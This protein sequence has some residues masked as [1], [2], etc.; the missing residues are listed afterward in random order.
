MRCVCVCVTVH[1]WVIDWATERVQYTNNFS[2]STH[3][4]TVFLFSH[5]RVHKHTHAMLLLH[6][7]TMTTANAAH[8][9]GPH[10]RRSSMV[11]SCNG[12]PACKLCKFGLTIPNY[13]FICI[14]SRLI[15]NMIFRTS[16]SLILNL[17]D[18]WFK[19][20]HKKTCLIFEAISKLLQQHT[21]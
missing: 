21:I 10:Q 19:W 7:I 3:S 6:C 1:K 5:I 2:L 8:S 15:E 13:D 11:T 9:V 20:K 4:S 18:Y 17:A 16:C 12:G 14:L